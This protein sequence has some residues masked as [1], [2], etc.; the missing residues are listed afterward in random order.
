MELL[1]R[2]DTRSVPLRDVPI[3]LTAGTSQNRA[4]RVPAAAPVVGKTKQAHA[5]RKVAAYIES[6]IDDMESQAGRSPPLELSQPRSRCPS[7]IIPA[8]RSETR[9]PGIRVAAVSFRPQAHGVL[10]PGSD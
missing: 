8:E 9:V 4:E 1:H 3:R 6:Q 10:G 7:V 5:R 2:F